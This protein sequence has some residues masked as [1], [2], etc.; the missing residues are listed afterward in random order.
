MKK[1]I[2]YF[3]VIILL[4][5]VTYFVISSLGENSNSKELEKK[6]DYSEYD[7][8]VGTYWTRSTEADTEFLRFRGDGSFSYYCACGNPVNDSDLCETYTYDEKTKTIKI[9]CYDKTNETISEI[10]IIN[11]TED[12]I[13]LS[14]DGEIRKFVKED[15]KDE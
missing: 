9:N 12:S 5:F 6:I 7:Y 11:Y 14:F 3:T 2:I 13:E 15:E 8:F 4:G 1:K 10:K